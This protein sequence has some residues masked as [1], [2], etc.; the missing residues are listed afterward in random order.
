MSEP[1]LD[2]DP[3]EGVA[4]SFLA[5]FRA[6]ERPSIAEYAARHT[7]LADQI[8]RLLAAFVLLE[9]DVSVEVDV[10]PAGRDSFAGRS[11]VVGDHRLLME[12]GQ[13]GSGAVDLA[14]Q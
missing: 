14:G 7:E 4:E 9:Q 11:G 10:A 6:G 5:R 1:P 8:R 3:F 2:R 12:V 13:G